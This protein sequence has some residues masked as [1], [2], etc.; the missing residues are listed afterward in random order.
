MKDLTG[1]AVSG[2]GSVRASNLTTNSLTTKISGSGTIIASG[3]VGDQD[4][5]ISGSG[6]LSSRAIDEQERQGTHLRQRKRKC[7]GYSDT[8][9]VTISGSG[10]LTYSGDPKVTQEIS[11]SGK[12]IKK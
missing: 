9:D 11:G 12:L 6:R 2:S 7:A 1:I 5:D 10:T 8:F 3:T 4:L